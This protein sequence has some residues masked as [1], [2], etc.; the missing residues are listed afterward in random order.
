MTCPLFWMCLRKVGPSTLSPAMFA[1]LA[2]LFFALSSIFTRWGLERAS[3]GAA[4]LVT[5]LANVVVFWPLFLI[6]APFS[7]ISSWAVL[8]FIAAG[9][10]GPFLARMLLFNGMARVGVSVATPLYNIQVLFAV[11]GGVLFFNE[12]LTPFVGLGT[13]VLLGGVVLLTLDSS[14]GS[15]GKPRRLVDMA[16]PLASGFFFAISFMLRKWGLQITPEVFL[17]LA[18]MASTSFFTA[19]VLAPVQGK[20]LS[21]PKGHPLVMFAIAGLLTNVAQLFSLTAILR[22][23]LVVVIPLQNTQPLF[24]LLLSA[25]FLR[26]LERVT[27][28]IIAGAMLMVAGAV[29]VNF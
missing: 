15:K 27:P 3:S 7:S 8:A 18:M 29:L 6:F 12:T 16:F 17:G 2:G 21:F 28:M 19:F 24:A 4:V 14:G 26:R 10:T 20:P 11:I 22:G 23:D 5:A 1:V 25:L 9:A 13:V